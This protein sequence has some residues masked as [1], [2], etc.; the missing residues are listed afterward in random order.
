MDKK[1]LDFTKEEKDEITGLLQEY[2]NIMA[3]KDPEDYS[4]LISMYLQNL[5]IDEDSVVKHAYVRWALA[6][7]IDSLRYPSESACAGCTGFRAERWWCSYFEDEALKTD[8]AKSCPI[9]SHNCDILMN[10]MNSEDLTLKSAVLD[11]LMAL[12]ED[13]GRN[14]CSNFDFL[15]TKAEEHAYV[16]QASWE[17]LKGQE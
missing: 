12:M 8:F 7:F 11:F 1:Q 10:N 9:G 15:L 13:K 2:F 14:T 6:Y 4:Y 17:E 3:R 5:E 16:I